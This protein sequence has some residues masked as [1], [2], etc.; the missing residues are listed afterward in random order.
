MLNLNDPREPRFPRTL[1]LVAAGALAPVSVSVAGLLAG[2]RVLEQ[3]ATTEFVEGQTRML[4]MLLLTSCASPRPICQRH[5]R[6]ANRQHRGLLGSQLERSEW[7]ARGR[8]HR[9]GPPGARPFQRRG[10]GV[11]GRL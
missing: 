3:D 5:L 6:R 10:G 4:R 9:H 7:T 1:R 8:P 11:R 2:S